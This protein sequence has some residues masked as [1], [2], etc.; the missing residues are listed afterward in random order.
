MEGPKN[1]YMTQKILALIH[2]KHKNEKPYHIYDNLSLAD[3][4]NA[5]Y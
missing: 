4:W 3:D 1:M 2:S 5:I